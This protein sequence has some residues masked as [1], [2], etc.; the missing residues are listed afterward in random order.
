MALNIGHDNYRISSSNIGPIK[1][2]ISCTEI[3]SII[4]KKNDKALFTALIR[5]R[6]LR[7]S[8]K[9]ILGLVTS[10]CTRKTVTWRPGAYLECKFTLHS[11]SSTL[12]G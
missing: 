11:F 7:Q 4:E 5:L 1:S 6:L 8:L 9:L 12:I 2:F 10:C 3:V